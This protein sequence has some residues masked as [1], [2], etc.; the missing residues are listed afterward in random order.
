[1]PDGRYKLRSYADAGAPLTLSDAVNAIRVFRR[2]MP[3][4][5]TSFYVTCYN[6]IPV[7]VE[8]TLADVVN[9]LKHYRDMI[10]HPAHLS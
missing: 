5:A 6:Y 2:L 10:T 9:S 4:A 8:L 1:M 3:A 7:G